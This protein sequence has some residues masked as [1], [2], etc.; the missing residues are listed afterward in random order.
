MHRQAE[1]LASE[2]IA[3]RGDKR[4]KVELTG[5]VNCLHVECVAFLFNTYLFLLLLLSLLCRMVKVTLFG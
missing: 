4:H 5:L 2:E 3:E 1:N